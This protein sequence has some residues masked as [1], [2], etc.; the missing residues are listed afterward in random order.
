LDIVGNPACTAQVNRAFRVQSKHAYTVLAQQYETMPLLAGLLSEKPYLLPHHRV[1]IIYCF[2]TGTAQICALD[3]KTIEPKSSPLA[4]TRLQCIRELTLPMLQDKAYF[5]RAIFNAI[6]PRLTEPFDPMTHVEIIEC[7]ESRLR[8]YPA[9]FASFNGDLNLANLQLS[10]VPRQ[11]RC[12]P[13][14]TL[15]NLENNN[16]RLLP[17]EIQTLSRLLYLNLRQNPLG[18]ETVKGVCKALAGLQT[19]VIDSEQ[20]NLVEMFAREKFPHLRVIVT[21]VIREEGFF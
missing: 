5:Y 3:F 4:P 8:V 21:Q 18:A 7:S 9:L 10:H 13:N 2:I 20:P 6:S 16:L 15:I 19:V 12:L 17:P 14:V 11:I 1:Q